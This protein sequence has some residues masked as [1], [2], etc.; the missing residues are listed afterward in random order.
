MCEVLAFGAISTAFIGQIFRI[1]NRFPARIGIRSLQF[2]IYI[3]DEVVLIL[4]GSDTSFISCS[5]S[6]SQQQNVIPS[7]EYSLRRVCDCIDIFL[8]VPT[9]VLPFTTEMSNKNDRR[10]SSLFGRKKSAEV[11]RSFR[12]SE[13]EEEESSSSISVA[14]P[15][16]KSSLKQNNEA[17]WSRH[18]APATMLVLPPPKRVSLGNIDI[19]HYQRILSDNPSVSSGPA[20]GIGW[21][22]EQQ[23]SLLL[24]EYEKLKPEPRKGQQLQIPRMVREEMLVESGI[25]SRRM[26]EA[27]REANADKHRRRSSVAMAEMEGAHIFMESAARKFKRLLKIEPS[28]KKQQEL[29]WKNAATTQKR[30]ATWSS[31]T[32]SDLI[33]PKQNEANA[34]AAATVQVDDIAEQKQTETQAVEETVQVSEDTTIQKQEAPEAEEIC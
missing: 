1:S 20:I 18:S 19:R 14:I 17:D 29:L 7:S 27:T 30:R 6:L 21:H 15:P 34:M 13:T 4:A 5:F 31:P 25:T 8:L 16:L 2:E 23:A 33:V 32:S 12:A 3:E 9:F 11:S 26:A 10:R 24:E 28:S 22:Y